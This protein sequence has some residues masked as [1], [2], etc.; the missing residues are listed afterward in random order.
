MNPIQSKTIQM[1]GRDVRY[2]TAGTGDPL[3]VIHGGGGDART[4]WNNIGELARFY[5]VYAPDLPGYGG[6]QRLDGQYF[7]PELSTFIDGFTRSLGLDTFH[8][9]GH[10]LG[11]G[12]AVN[13]ALDFPK[14]IKKL[15]LVSS[16]CLGN[17][18]AF[19]V[20]LFCL[21]ALLKL[22][23]GLALA[24]LKG[25]KWVFEQLNLKEYVVPISP[26]SVY[27]GGLITNFKRQT[28][29]LKNRLSE[30][31]M[32]TLLVWGA[33]DS[34]IPVMHAY[35][36]AAVMPHAQ[37]KVFSKVGHDVHRDELAGFS[38]A[39]SGFLG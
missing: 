23:G 3:V 24:G 33:K 21:P 6:S 11:G 15:V 29:V 22:M 39:V 20:R 12:I 18:I 31:A 14:R 38:S 9:V 2:Y 4:W 36:A 13:Y 37:V 8:L 34:I 1:D 32:P 19:W 16:L 30:L 25:V 7:I 10:S 35:Q 27:V 26:A 5:T 17:E 28:L